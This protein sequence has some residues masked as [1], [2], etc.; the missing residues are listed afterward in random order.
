MNQPPIERTLTVLMKPERFVLTMDQ[1]IWDSQHPSPQEGEL[2]FFWDDQRQGLYSSFV[3]LF[4]PNQKAY[5]AVA[6]RIRNILLPFSLVEFN[7]VGHPV[8]EHPISHRRPNLSIEFYRAR[9]LE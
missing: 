1:L 4:W 3:Q 8:F 7:S 9:C 6:L 5:D 2:R